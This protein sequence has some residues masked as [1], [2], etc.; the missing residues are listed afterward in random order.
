MGWR[1]GQLDMFRGVGPR[2]SLVA[3]IA[4]NLPDLDILLYALGRDVGTW[5]HRGFTHSLLG[6]PVLVALGAGAS[7]RWLRTGRFRDHLKLWAV[8]LASH[9]ILDVPTTWGTQL[10][11]PN[12]QRFGLALIF[13]VDPMFWLTLGLVPWGL[14][15]SG[16]G[17]HRAAVA[18]IL[19]LVAWFG[20]SAAGKMAALSQAPERVEA[21]AAPLAPL[22]WTA[23]TKPQP[24]DT[25]VR[26]YFLTP[27]SGEPAGTFGAPRGAAWEAVMATHTGERD[28]WMSIAPAILRQTVEG[29]VTTIGVVDIAYSGWLD[30]DSFRF[31]HV[32]SVAADGTVTREGG[33]QRRDAGEAIGGA[34]R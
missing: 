2:A 16:V 21:V 1:I 23:F 33:T 11:W 14:R 9:A 10:L 34:M 28:T 6:W 12:D 32:Y 22:H 8:A 5:E 26:R 3:L 27:W 20:V 25:E 13:I 15:R 24:G 30:P 4:A 7:F 17:A 29:G 31:G 18:A 19:S